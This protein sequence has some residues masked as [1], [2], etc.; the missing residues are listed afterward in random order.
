MI[1]LNFKT[2]GQ[3]PAIIILHGLF[4]SLD[5]WLSLARKLAE[6]Y[7]VYLIDQRNHGKSPHT[8]EFSY[9]LLA[10]DLHTFMDEQG[11]Y[12]AHLIGHSM[13]GKVVM[14]FAGLYPDR[15]DKLVVVDMANRQYKPHHTE[16][17]EALH[18]LKLDQLKARSEAA[19]FFEKRVPE[20]GVRQFLLKNLGR[21]RGNTYQWKFNLSS[22]SSH[23]QEILAE[24]EVD[25]PYEGPTLFISGGNSAYVEHADQED[26]LDS[27][28][29]ANFVEI[30][31][32]GHWVHAEAPGRFLEEVEA[33]LQDK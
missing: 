9:D 25:F 13:G 6:N 19:A 1:Q 32:V 16:I 12:Q 8:D 15:I 31:G 27:F 24:V 22:L 5:N 17:F 11:I 26:L 30:A 10:E 3:G 28:P 7:S 14:Q 23:Y 29:Q 18:A 2:L 21:E 4:G 33:F 20:E